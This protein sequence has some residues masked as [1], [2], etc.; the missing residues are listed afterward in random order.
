MLFGYPLFCRLRKPEFFGFSL[1]SKLFWDKP[2]C[3]T[4]IELI[5]GATGGGKTKFDE[6]YSHFIP[7]DTYKYHLSS[8]EIRTHRSRFSTT[9][10]L[11]W[12]P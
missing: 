9:W 10:T 11:P 6:T 4:R 2:T 5:R 12:R 1:L 8:R 7:F 3:Y